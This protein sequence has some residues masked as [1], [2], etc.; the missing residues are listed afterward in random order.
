MRKSIQT[1]LSV[2]LSAGAITLS[3]CGG[4]AP[5]GQDAAGESAAAADAPAAGDAA[6]ETGS[7]TLA[8]QNAVRSARGYL[9]ISG[10][11]RDGLI[12]QLSSDA[13]DGYAKADAMAAVDSLGIDWNEQA[14]RSAREYLELTGF[15][16]KG[17]VEQ[18]SSS[19]GEKYTVEQAAYGAKQAGIC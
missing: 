18:L 3:A 1:A 4:P 6:A 13:G 5:S 11:S 19:A 10:F 7:L 9:E 14:A 8:Q 16:C 2:V 15:S 17:L 12:F